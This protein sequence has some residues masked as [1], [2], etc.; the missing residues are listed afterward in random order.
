[1]GFV[2]KEI[3]GENTGIN[4]T[5]NKNT[6]E[7]KSFVERQE[8]IK[9]ANVEKQKAIAEGKILFPELVDQKVYRKSCLFKIDAKIVAHLKYISHCTHIPQVKIL[10]MLIE[11]AYKSYKETK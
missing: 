4:K 6:S 9:K 8:D 3:L 5:L 10:E 11:K 7:E 2:K 1:M